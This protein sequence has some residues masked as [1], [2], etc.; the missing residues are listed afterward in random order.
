M[1]VT[2][3][4]STHLRSIL[5]P[6]AMR[7]DMPNYTRTLSDSFVAGALDEDTRSDFSSGDGGELEGDPPKMCAAH[8]SSALALNA[9]R[10]FRSH[11]ER[12][13]LVGLEGFTQAKFEKKLPT[14]LLGNPPNLDFVVRGPAGVVAV[15]SK[16]TEVLGAKRAKFAAS[17]EGAVA[18]LAGPAWTDLYRSL[19]DDP[20]RFRHL[21]AAQLVKHYLG[22]RNSLVDAKGELV[23]MYVFWEPK[24]AADSAV[25]V[26]H[27]RE[28]EEF[29]GS[30]RDGNVTFH[31]IS[32]SR[33]WD[34][35]EEESDW[36]GMGDHVSALRARYELVVPA[37]DAE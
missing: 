14:G 23:L 15:E 12:L 6:D 22:V 7:R 10:P 3:A 1:D 2:T 25:F 28:V 26:R 13:K 35:W 31:S 30:V 8:S 9:F 5:G 36:D 24:N 19:R 18:R 32:Y 37:H 17:Y 21:D 27:R 29:G 4:I 34:R 11:P 16:F 20:S 33:L